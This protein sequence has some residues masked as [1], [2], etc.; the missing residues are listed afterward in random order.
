MTTAT[1]GEL[2]H[3]HTQHDHIT[4]IMTGTDGFLNVFLVLKAVNLTQFPGHT[5]GLK[6]RSALAVTSNRA[7]KSAIC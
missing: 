5:N 4:I 6:S 2:T 7:A 1:N 3:T